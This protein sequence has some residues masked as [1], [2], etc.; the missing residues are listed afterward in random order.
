MDFL[1]RRDRGIEAAKAIFRRDENCVAACKA[2]TQRTSEQCFD[3]WR[4][5]SS[6]DL[7]GFYA[8]QMG[9]TTTSCQRELTGQSEPFDRRKQT[10]T[11]APNGLLI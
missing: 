2:T 1:L 8:R 10:P 11:V 7:W 6:G 3:A 4:S 9:G 5:P